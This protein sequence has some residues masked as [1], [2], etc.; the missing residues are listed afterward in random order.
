MATQHIR[1]ALSHFDQGKL[2]LQFFLMKILPVFHGIN[3][4]PSLLQSD[5]LDVTFDA[6]LPLPPPNEPAMSPDAICD[7]DTPDSI[8]DFLRDEEFQEYFGNMDQARHAMEALLAKAPI[9]LLR[10]EKEHLRF[11]DPHMQRLLVGAVPAYQ[12]WQLGSSRSVF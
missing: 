9:G 8:T 11:V 7:L 1:P 12:N 10:E 6:A 4:A 5:E 2:K 3:F